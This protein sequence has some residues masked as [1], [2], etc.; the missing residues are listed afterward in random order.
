MMSHNV[1]RGLEPFACDFVEVQR[2]HHLIACTPAI[3]A[4]IL[5][6]DYLPFKSQREGPFCG[7]ARLRC[8]M[9]AGS[10]GNFM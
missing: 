7:E 5:S 6:S 1:E 8:S 4:I 10:M 9:T 2:L 3:A